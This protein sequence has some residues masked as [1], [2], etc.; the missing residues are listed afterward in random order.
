MDFE[1]YKL[2]LILDEWGNYFTRYGFDITAI[3]VIGFLYFFGN[4]NLR[5]CKIPL[6]KKLI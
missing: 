5:Y 6:G 3:M 2:A 1:P 4:L